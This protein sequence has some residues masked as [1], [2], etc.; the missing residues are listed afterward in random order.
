LGIRTRIFTSEPC[1]TI[2]DGETELER[3]SVYLIQLYRL[4]TLPEQKLLEI[5]ELLPDTMTIEQ[6]N[7]W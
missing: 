1:R 5:E 4:N 6:C 2:R 3:N 7:S